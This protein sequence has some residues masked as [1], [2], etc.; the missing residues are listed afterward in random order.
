MIRLMGK[1]IILFIF[2]LALLDGGIAAGYYYY[3]LPMRM[4]QD[5]KLSDLKAAVEAR[6]QEVAKM[7][8]EFVLLQSQ[9]RNFKELEYSGF[10]NN[11][12]RAA[13][14][15]LLNDLSNKAGLLKASVKIKKGELIADSQAEA[16]KQVVLKSQVIIPTDS[17]DD[18]DVYTFMRFLEQKLPGTVDVTSLKLDRR[19]VLNAAMLRRIGSGV[20]S[21]LVN[22]E[23]VFDWYTMIPKDVTVPSEK[24]N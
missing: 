14:T 22:T 21:P 7:K 5:Q 16:A 18:V 4:E 11:Q 1:K 24:G 20:P 13:A 12:N 10:F 8:E 19:E 9:L 15:D 17:L 3:L 23:I 6:R 2:F